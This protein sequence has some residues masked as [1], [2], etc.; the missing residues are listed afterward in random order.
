MSMKDFFSAVALIESRPEKAFFAGPRPESLIEAAEKCL[1][2]IFPP[3][4]R[5]FLLLF[6]AG[7][8]GS[9]EFYGVINDDFETGPIPDGIWCTLDERKQIGLAKELVVVGISS[10]GELHCIDT[11]IKP[12][13]PVFYYQSHLRPDEQPPREIAGEDFGAFFLEQ[14]RTE[15]KY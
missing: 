14:V 6:G 10:Y 3:T 11:N 8:F 5:Q 9:E 15:L 1:G 13:S 4:Y 2:V 12:E 7:S